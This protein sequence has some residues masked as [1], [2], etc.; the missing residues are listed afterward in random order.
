MCPITNSTKFDVIS[1]RNSGFKDTTLYTNVSLCARKQN[2]RH[3]REYY[4]VTG[5]PLQPKT[6][7]QRWCLFGW[8]SFQRGVCIYRWNGKVFQIFDSFS[9]EFTSF[10]NLLMW[11]KKK[12][13]EKNLHKNLCRKFTFGSDSN[14]WFLNKFFFDKNVAIAFETICLHFLLLLASSFAAIHIWISVNS[15]WLMRRNHYV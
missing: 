4:I 8:W 3:K 13:S 7:K 15:I 1:I 11:M 12:I 2:Q 9:Y 14:D 6:D 5:S 10:L